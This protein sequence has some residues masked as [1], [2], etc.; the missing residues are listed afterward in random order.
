V[1]VDLEALRRGH[2]D[3]GPGTDPPLIGEGYDDWHHGRTEYGRAL[4]RAVPAILAALE[5]AERIEAAARR[6]RVETFGASVLVIG[7]DELTAS[8][9]VPS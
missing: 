5:R 1:S 9:E 7:L 4:L 8:L 3:Y 2:A 6:V